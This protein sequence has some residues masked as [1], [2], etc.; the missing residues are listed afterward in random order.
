MA[1]PLMNLDLPVVGPLGTAGP[2]W[3]TKLNTAITLIDS[4]DHTP[5][6]G[7]QIPSAALNINSDLSVAGFNLTGIKSTRFNS[8]GSPLGTA[9]DKNCIYVSGGELYYNDAAGTQIQL[10]S[11]GGINL[12]SVGSIGGDYSTSSASLNYSD[13]TKTFTFKQDATKTANIL[14]GDVAVTEN[15]SGGNSVTLKAPTGLAAAYNLT[16]PAAVP[17]STLPITSTTGG[18]LAFSSVTQSM[19]AS[20]ATG[21]SVPAGGIAISD[22]SGAYV[23]TSSTEADV[24]NLSVTITTTGRPVLVMLIPSGV[25]YT[26]GVVG[27]SNPS[28]S[29]TSSQIRIRVYRDSTNLTETQ[30]GQANSSLNETGFVPCGAVSTIDVVGAGTYVYKITAFIITDGGTPGGFITH[31]KLVAFEL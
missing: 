4:H 6:K 12:T 20:R 19:L 29:G 1:T 3:A 15:V 24:T 13:S 22:S 17:G 31:C 30:A 10:T 16:F 8:Q 9:S 18:V 14:A 23:T 11:A 7:G 27:C 26:G 21:T 25:N 2:D 28:V 5:G